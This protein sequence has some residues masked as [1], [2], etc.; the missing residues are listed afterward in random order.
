MTLNLILLMLGMLLLLPDVYI[1]LGVIDE[2]SLLT[3]ALFLLPTFAYLGIIVRIVASDTMRRNDLN[4]LFWLT[5]CVPVPL[6][7]FTAV[8]LLGR[9]VGLFIEPAATVFNWA[10][11]I[12]ALTWL[13]VALYGITF[14]WKEVKVRRHKLSFPKLPAEFD[15]YRIAH[16]SDLHL[17]TYDLA[18]EVVDRI[19]EKVNELKPDMI[20]FTG[21]LINLSPDEAEPYREALSR[22]KAPDGIYSVLGNHDYCIYGLPD[23]KLTPE[24][25]LS[26]LIHLQNEMGWNLLRNE[27]VEIRRGEDSIAI[28]GVDNAG[29]GRFFPDRSDLPAALSET[30]DKDFKILLSHDPSQWRRQVLPASDIDLTLSGHTHAMQLRVGPFSPASLLYREWA[31]LYCDDNRALL[32][33]TGTGS[34]FAFRFGTAPEINFITLTR[35]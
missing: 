21:D 7:I 25:G 5:L 1:L 19:V 18:P 17:G 20:V 27:A 2:S 11:T 10:G 15:G 13:A 14:G 35:P 12:I 32:V 8:S 26:R 23:S 30:S 33:S 3:K 6:L 22:L 31:G 28:A 29:G 34:S 9:V 16:L 4:T 24:H